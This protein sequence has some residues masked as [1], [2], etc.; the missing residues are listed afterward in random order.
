[1]PE[2]FEAGG[3]NAIPILEEVPELSITTDDGNLLI[4]S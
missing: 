2:A 1:M 4:Y 3:E